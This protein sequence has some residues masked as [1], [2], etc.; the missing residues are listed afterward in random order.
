MKKHYV[1]VFCLALVCTLAEGA[2]PGPSCSLSSNLNGPVVVY[3][4][5]RNPAFSENVWGA[6]VSTTSA[7]HSG[8][9]A[10]TVTFNESW[11]G[12]EFNSYM[13]FAPGT[14]GSI[15]LAVRGS[16]SGH[17]VRIY[18][19]DK[20]GGKLGVDVDLSEYFVGGFTPSW[21][22]AEIPVSDMYESLSLPIGG[23]GIQSE[24]AGTI[25]IDDI[26]LVAPEPQGLVTLYSEHPRA[27]LHS[28]LS[29]IS[30]E[31]SNP[32]AGKK[33]IKLQVNN[34]WGG[35][36]LHSNRPIS[37][38]DFG[39][40]TLAVKTNTPDL[41]LYIY[42]VN[43]D[44]DRIGLAKPLSSFLH[45]GAI[46]SNWQVAWVP[47]QALIPHPK[48]GTFVFNGIGIESTATGTVW[49]DEVKIVEKLQ[50]PL[51]EVEVG[52]IGNGFHFGSDWDVPGSKCNGDWL[53]H[54]GADYTNNQVAGKTVLAAHAGKVVAVH[55]D[56]N[57]Q[58]GWHVVVQSV[59]KAFTTTYTHLI[60]PSVSIGQ[61]VT[62]GEFLGKTAAIQSGPHLDFKIRFGDYDLARSIRGALPRVPCGGLPVFPE[63]FVNPELVDWQ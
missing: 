16:M 31:T 19:L 17:N 44:G 63:K 57:P 51:P 38:N 9:S 35:L 37:E 47:I 49:V 56:S 60:T 13:P 20:T 27:K 2:L 46:P 24:I 33:A 41:D 50:W 58:W 55:N 22:M 28:W 12:I 15:Q 1:Y 52:D 8:N 14:I 6:T 34:S 11:S 53:L 7:A 61:V 62:K 45:G 21:Q 4:D 40:I 43:E 23:L 42:A 48:P 26:K 18:L 30:T 59:G 25:W 54:V 10:L 36:T 39:A 29:H 5:Y 3:D 32:F